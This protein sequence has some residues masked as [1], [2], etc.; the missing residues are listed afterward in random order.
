MKK[1]NPLPKVKARKFTM[2]Q[3]PAVIDVQSLYNSMVEMERRLREIQMENIN[4]RAV[5]HNSRES[6]DDIFRIPDSIKSLPTFDGKKKQATAWVQ[7]VR[8]ALHRFRNRVSD[9]TL[10]MYEQCV[11]NKVIGEARDILCSNGN[12]QNFE[13]AAKVLLGSFGDKNTIATYQTQIWNMK[14]ENSLHNYY[15]KAKELMVNIKSLAK[16]NKIYAA[17]WEAIN[18]F[19]EQESLAAFINGLQKPYFGYA[20]TAQP[21]D[22]ESAYAFLCRFQCAE[23]TKKHTNQHHNSSNHQQQTKGHFQ[24]PSNFQGK[25][26]GQ[27]FRQNKPFGNNPTKSDRSKIT[28]MDVDPSLRSKQ[29]KVFNHDSEPVEDTHEEIQE[30]LSDSESEE[31]INFQIVT[32]KQIQR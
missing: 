23:M 19:I 14:M 16:E 24:N 26:Q 12:P 13:E 10:E 1:F 2:E 21:D 27:N 30:D 31:E 7:T 29:G 17:N 9:E 25:N 5:A 32:A 11:L 28:P 18:L 6:M 3:Q 8:T 15:K 20:Q 4:L 22:I